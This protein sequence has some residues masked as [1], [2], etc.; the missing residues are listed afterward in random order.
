MRTLQ[1]V[2]AWPV[3]A[4]V[5]TTLA[6]FLPLMFWPGVAGKFMRYLPVTVFTILSGSLMYALF[7][8]PAMGAVF[9]KAGL[10]SGKSVRTLQQLESGDPTGLPG[11]NRL[12]CKIVAMVQHPCPVDDFR[13]CNSSCE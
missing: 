12:V 3:V 1:N 2:C 9:G 4:S 10:V 6:A 8:G 5:A 13:H 7:L 11:I